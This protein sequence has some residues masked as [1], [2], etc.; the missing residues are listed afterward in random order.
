MLIICFM[1]TL[2]GFAEFEIDSNGQKGMQA[3]T[4]KLTYHM[5]FSF[6]S[7]Y[8]KYLYKRNGFLPIS[9]DFCVSG[10]SKRFV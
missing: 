6:S 10:S 8:Q 5:R 7:K 2:S 1:W 9:I 4:W 3:N